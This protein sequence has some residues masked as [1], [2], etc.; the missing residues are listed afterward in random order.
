MESLSFGKS[1]GYV[2][3]AL[4]SGECPE[5]RIIDRLPLV[6][7]FLFPNFVLA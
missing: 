3:Q 5:T 4:K 6:S 7:I 2:N 1:T